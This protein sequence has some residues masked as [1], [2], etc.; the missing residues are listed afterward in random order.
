MKLIASAEN[1]QARA[2]LVALMNRIPIGG[3]LEIETIQDVLG[4][5]LAK[6]RHVWEAARK[7]A[8]D[9]HGVLFESVH[10]QGYK[11]LATE[12]VPLVGERA[13]VFIRGK[14]R[15]AS[16]NIEGALKLTNDVPKMTRRR[17]YGEIAMLGVIQAAARSSSVTKAEKDVDRVRA[18]SVAESAKIL[19]EGLQN[20]THD[21]TRT[22]TI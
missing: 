3:L 16:R 2:N 8:V 21:P 15:R 13:R 10:G 6:K 22:E 18:P 12:E 11:R 1:A 17:C 14:A 19:A 9:E 7:D 5:P 4:G 20:Q